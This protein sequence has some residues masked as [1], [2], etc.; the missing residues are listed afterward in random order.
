MNILELK[1]VSKVFDKPD[2]STFTALRNISLSVKKGETF[3][4][5]GPN[6]SGKTTLL[7][8]IAL[9][10]E[11]T[12]GDIY[13][14]GKNIKKYSGKEKI[15]YRRKIS[16]VRQKPVVLNTS[17]ANNVAFPL[18]IK[19]IS[20]KVIYDKLI[21]I[22]KRVGLSSFANTNARKLSGGEVQRVVIAMNF[23]S[24][25]DLYLL[26][27]VTANLDPQNLLIFEKFLKEIRND[28]EKTL[29]LST[30][31][32]MEAIKLADRIAVLINGEITQ[33]GKPSEIFTSPNDEFTAVFLGY[34][35]IFKGKSFFNEKLQL[36]HVQVGDLEITT[37][38]EKEGDVKIC[39]HPESIVIGKNAPIET[40]FRNI[41]KAKVLEIKE[42]GNICHI[43][44]EARKQK[45]LISITKLSRENLQ[46]K[47]NSKVYISFKATDV[48]VL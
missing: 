31:D 22:L 24:P 9:L 10:L 33:I 40:S 39:I 23:I 14:K 36:N 35:N 45:F 25:A 8:L 16:Y 4:I 5:I 29:I 17:V 6:G 34:N 44:V 43:I 26:D 1:N 7:K 41:F 42:L 13:F 27:E 38:D 32:P 19:N 12:L 18:L 37:S 3:V 11:P 48:K 15:N 46:L 2:K 47:I 30:H 28:S 21:E 20:K